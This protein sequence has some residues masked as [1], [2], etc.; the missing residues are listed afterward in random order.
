MVQKLRRCK[1][2]GREAHYLTHSGY[3]PKC[4]DEVQMEAIRQLMLHQ[5]PIFDKWL[6]NTMR[7]LAKYKEK[8]GVRD[9]RESRKAGRTK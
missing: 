6:V 4:S 2:C 7:G 1:R 9:A 8:G 3:C 5:G